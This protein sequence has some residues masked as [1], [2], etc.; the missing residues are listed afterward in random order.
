MSTTTDPGPAAE[1]G[2]A[3]GRASDK[4]TIL[5][6]WGILALLVALILAAVGYVGWQLT[7][8]ADE[9]V[10]SQR[11][12]VMAAADKFVQRVNDYGPEDIGS[13]KKTM[14]TYREKVGE[15]LTPKFEKSFLG[16]VAFAEATVVQQGVGRTSDVHSTAV[17]GLDED[18][19]TVLVVAELAISYPKSEGSEERAEAARQLARTE[20]E[21][22][23]QNG[24]WLVDDW[25]PAEEAPTAEPSEGVTP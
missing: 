13:D 6:R 19:A 9:S 2:A 8:G 20:V 1:T 22:V 14:P 15:L 24:E 25:Y 18:S 16:N 23:K 5:L 7:R 11:E 17:A 12:Q 4:R 21:L 3:S 10:V